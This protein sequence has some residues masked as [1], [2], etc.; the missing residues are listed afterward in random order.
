MNDSSKQV[1]PQE[2]R[3]SEPALT[4]AVDVIETPEGITLWLDMP[5][6]PKESLQVRV[7]ND[8]LNI[9][10]SANFAA[11]PGLEQIYVEQRLTRYRR[12]FT[13][14]RELDAGRVEAS[15]KDGVLCVKLPRAEAARPR[16]VE[17]RMG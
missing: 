15:F 17:V 10:G 9:E 16:R 3:Q 11:P 14:S 1:H 12:S 8:A 6:V 4:P 7:D 2:V 5:G 13:L